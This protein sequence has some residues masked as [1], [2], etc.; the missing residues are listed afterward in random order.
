[1]TVIAYEDIGL[2]NPMIGPKVEAAIAASER[3]GLPEGRIP[4]GDIVIEMALSPKSNSG[5]LALDAA[6]RY[7]NMPFEFYRDWLEVANDEIRHFLMLEKL[8]KEL[9]G[10]YGEFEVHKNLFEAMQQTPDLLSRMSCIPRYLEANNCLLSCRM[11]NL[12][13]SWLV[14]EQSSMPM[15]GLSPS[16]RFISSYILTYISICPTS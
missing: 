5:H 9:N 10:F 2:A 7:Q 14:S 16:V 4:L 1:M 3:L 15:V 11:E 13:M 12:A 6:L 8:L